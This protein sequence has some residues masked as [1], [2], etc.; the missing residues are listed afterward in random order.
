MNCLSLNTRKLY[1]L[2]LFQLVGGP[3]VLL[4]VLLFSKFSVRHVAERGVVVGIVET[5][6]SQEWKSAMQDLLQ[7][8]AGLP[9]TQQ[10]K[11]PVKV[12]DAKQKIFAIELDR[13]TAIVLLETPPATP[14]SLSDSIVIARAHA[15]PIPP[16]RNV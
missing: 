15:P 6:K 16:P 2:A 12:K 4:A 9:S 7:E 10:D 1:L 8:A 3:L 5:A 11:L 13:P 14:W